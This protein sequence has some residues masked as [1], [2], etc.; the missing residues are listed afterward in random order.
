MLKYSELIN[1]LTESQKINVLT[2]ISVLFSDDMPYLALPRFKTGEFDK[3]ARD[4]YPSIASLANSWDGKLVG[5]VA[6]AVT[7]NMSNNGIALAFIRGPKI[8]LDPYQAAAS[9][10]PL[11]AS[12]LTRECVAAAEGAGIHACLTDFHL[13]NGDVE[14]MDTLPNRRTIEE[15]IVKPFA[16][17]ALGAKCKALVAGDALRGDVYSDVNQKIALKGVNGTNAEFV[18]CESAGAATV[19]Y[20]QNGVICFKGSELA[21]EGALKRYYKLSRAIEKGSASPEDL[22]SEIAAGRAISPEDI[23]SGVDRLLDL[24][25]TCTK[26]EYEIWSVENEE[27]L[28]RRAALHSAVLLQNNEKILPLNA[29][30][31]IAVIG[32]IGRTSDGTLAKRVEGLM[33]EKGY[34]SVGYERGYDISGARDKELVNDAV[35]AAESADAVILFL[36]FDGEHGRWIGQEKNLRLPANQCELAYALRKIKNKVIAVISSEFSFDIGDVE[37][38]A[39]VML[40]PAE[41]KYGAEAAADI[42]AGNFDPCGRLAATLYRDTDHAFTKQRMYHARGMMSGPFIGYRY[43]DTAEYNVGYPFGHGLHYGSVAYY[44]P[45]ISGNTVKVHVK[46]TGKTPTTT[47]LQVYAGLDSSSVIRPKKELVGFERV[48]LE[49]RERKTVEITISLPKVYVSDKDTYEGEAGQYTVYVGESVS[50]IKFALPFTVAGETLCTDGEDRS[51]Y[52]QS[53]SNIISENF[54]LEANYKL[55]NRT[56]KNIVCGCALVALAV[57]LQVY[58]SIAEVY[59][60]F[61]QLFSAALVAFS[62][63]F[64][65]T[66]AIDRRK[67]DIKDKEAAEKENAKQFADAQVISQLSTE[68]MFKDEFD[69]EPITVDEQSATSESADDAEYYTYVDQD[70]TFEAAA[71]EF[72]S[73]ASEHGIKVDTNTAR[74]IFA[75]MASSRLMLV[76]GMEDGQFKSLVMLLAEYFE[77]AVYLDRLPDA[78]ED[79]QELLFGLDA[80]GVRSKTAFLTAIESGRELRQNIHIAAMTNADGSVFENGFAEIIKYAKNPKGYNC[81]CA[82]NEKNIKTPYQIPQNVWVIVNVKPGVLFESIGTNVLETACVLRAAFT[83]CQK[84]SS[85]KEYRKFKYYQM[86]YLSARVVN[87]FE[88]DEELWKRVDRFVAFAKRAVP[89]SIGNKQWLGMEKYAAVYLACGGDKQDTVDRMLTARLAPTL[90]A[91]LCN[92]DEHDELASVAEEIFG[93][94]NVESCCKLI[95]EA[96]KNRIQNKR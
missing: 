71:A 14:W 28:A 77:S 51:R 3:Y 52:L 24:V 38:F 34:T 1:K 62:A 22:T 85:P 82:A 50:D 8:K 56:V 57:V 21:L 15:Y 44:M 25:F 47:V 32:D 89:V 6:T 95:K 2:D 96:Q 10:D 65:I 86:D 5:E 30:K 70:F 16:D 78:C 39:G 59:S 92:C 60:L 37:G 18:I 72:E 43:Y 20:I 17:V 63:V 46:N 27:E 33:T 26:H 90:D 49:P 69:L 19:K 73:Y 61:M 9:E 41:A 75:S 79:S 12:I 35:R 88:L 48:H 74:D 23:D 11:L 45:S 53:E 84:Q 40:L 67:A 83:P 94:G 4:M 7:E 31:R 54:T 93:E 29:Q 91:L 81:I 68:Q 55:M 42:I 64:F 80:G 58:C 87:R 76:N 66:E 13:N 36:G